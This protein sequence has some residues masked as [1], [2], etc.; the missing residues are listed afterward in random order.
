MIKIVNASKKI[1]DTFVLKNINIDIPKGSVV[2]FTGH[3]GSGKTMLFRAICNFINLSEGEVYV[4]GIKVEPD[5][6]YPAS[7]GVILETPGFISGFSGYKNLEYLASIKNFIG[8]NEIEEIL[9]KV[10]L[11]DKKGM[12]VRKYSLG[13][14]QR[15]AIAQA[16]MEEPE[17]IV[18]DEPINALDKEGVNIFID[19]IKSMKGKNKTILISSHN[20]VDIEDLFDMVIEMDEGRIYSISETKRGK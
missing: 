5:K 6:S 7:L 16:V 15:L 3:N 12:A 11:Y 14:K 9:K 8:R 18:L 1:G 17:L 19:L 4:N 2:A 10:G 20:I 13:M